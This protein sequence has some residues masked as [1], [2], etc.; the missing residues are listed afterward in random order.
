VVFIKKIDFKLTAV[1]LWAMLSIIFHLISDHYINS[2]FSQPIDVDISH[3]ISGRYIATMNLEPNTHYGYVSAAEFDHSSRFAFVYPPKITINSEGVD[4]INGGSAYSLS[5]KW[6]RKNKVS[7][8]K[9]YFGS[10]ITPD[11]SNA[12][13][14]EGRAPATYNNHEV[15]LFKNIN[16]YY[17][18][19]SWLEAGSIFLTVLLGWIFIIQSMVGNFISLIRKVIR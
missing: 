4:F 18:Y 7:F 9:R 11:N 19:L 12:Y 3:K 6:V 14:I 10:F 13:V 17:F 15:Y 5:K 1:L 16:E 8:E 2:I